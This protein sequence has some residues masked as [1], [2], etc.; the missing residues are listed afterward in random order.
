MPLVRVQSEHIEHLA[1]VTAD[2]LPVLLHK[3]NE[4]YEAATAMANDLSA[5]YQ[6]LET[7]RAAGA[8]RSAALLNAD[9]GGDDTDQPA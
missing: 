9:A 8:E 4:L 3:V 2:D 6:E 5:L 7:I 1:S